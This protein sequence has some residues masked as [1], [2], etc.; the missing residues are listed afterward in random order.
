VELYKDEKLVGFTGRHIFEGNDSCPYVSWMKWFIRRRCMSYNWL[1]LPYTFAQF[2]EDVKDVEWLHGTNSSIR[3]DWALKAGLWD[4]HVK[5]QD[6]HSFA[7]KLHPFLVDGYRID[8]K[9]EPALLR[10]MDIE[11][12]MEK[13]SFSFSREWENN[14][15]YCKKVIF[16]Y[17][18]SRIKFYPIYIYIGV[19]LK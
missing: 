8:F 14:F 3:R 19:S 10:R 9:K 1:K 11:G 18:P 7:F 5:N 4:T 17:F 13:R 15:N 6:E 2:D 16:K 12:G